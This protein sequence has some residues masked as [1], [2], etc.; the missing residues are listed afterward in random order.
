M[1]TALKAGIAALALFAAAPASAALT[2]VAPCDASRTNPD[3]EACAGYYDGNLL[4]NADIGDI[5]AALDVLG[6]GTFEDIVWSDVEDTKAFFD[7]SGGVLNFDDPLV[8]EQILGIHFGGAG[9]FDHSVTVF[10]LFNFA[11]PTSSITLNQDGFSDA[12]LIG[13]A[14]PEPAT[15]AMMLLGFGAVGFTLRRRRR[16]LMPQVA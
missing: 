4:N 1:K 13:G 3:A 11:T 6:G 7:E 15:W 12:I 14:V 10:Y 5:N 9:E 2:I 8:G 16:V